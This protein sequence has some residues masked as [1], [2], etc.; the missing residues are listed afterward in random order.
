MK[1]AG[2]WLLTIADPKQRYRP[3]P[4]SDRFKN[5]QR[6]SD[7]GKRC[8]REAPQET[9]GPPAKRSAVDEQ[10]GG[11]REDA[12]QSLSDETRETPSEEE[13]RKKKGGEDEGSGDKL[14]L[15]EKGENRI[16]PQEEVEEEAGKGK[17]G[18]EKPQEKNNELIAGE[19]MNSTENEKEVA[20][21]P[22]TAPTSGDEQ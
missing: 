14:N 12:K 16:H 1:H 4:T 21:S 13:Q 18:S 8:R 19:K 20:H 15:E 17:V 5:Q 7:R 2:P 22:P 10:E 6:S 3:H 11:E 9:E